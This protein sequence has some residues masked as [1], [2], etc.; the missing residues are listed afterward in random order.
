MMTWSFTFRKCRLI[1]FIVINVNKTD[2]FLSFCFL[3]QPNFNS[4][5]KINWTSCQLQLRRAQSLTATVTR[6]AYAATAG[7]GDGFGGR[8]RWHVKTRAPF[9]GSSCV[10]PLDEPHFW[11]PQGNSKKFISDHAT[12]KHSC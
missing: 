6:L 12:V 7:L 5:K 3:N 11:Q 10:H 9:G 4:T 2:F 8:C 1:D